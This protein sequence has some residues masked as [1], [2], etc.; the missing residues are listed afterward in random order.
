MQSYG[1]LPDYSTLQTI[2]HVLPQTLTDEWK[3]YLGEDALND[4]LPVVINTLGNLCFLSQAANSH[5]GRDPFVSKVADYTDVTALTKDLKER[6]AKNVHWDIAAIQDRS[7]DLA[8]YAV[9]IWS[10]EL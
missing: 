10:W 3:K 7:E 5:A 6:V 4:K 9:R 8:K 2:E 1:Q